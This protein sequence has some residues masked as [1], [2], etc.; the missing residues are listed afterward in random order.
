VGIPVL[1]HPILPHAVPL[2]GGEEGDVLRWTLAP[3]LEVVAVDGVEL[4]LT[5]RSMWKWQ[6]RCTDGRMHMYIS[7]RCMKIATSMIECGDRC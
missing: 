3:V 2:V 6:N 4:L 7:Q 1:N 5:K